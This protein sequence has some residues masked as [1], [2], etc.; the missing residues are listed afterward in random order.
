MNP[1]AAE[2]ND[3]RPNHK[4]F[5]TN[6]IA[7]NFFSFMA[8][9][10]AFTQGNMMQYI[11]NK[12]TKIEIGPFPFIVISLF[13]KILKTMSKTYDKNIIIKIFILLHTNSQLFSE[14]T[15]IKLPK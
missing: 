7:K 8:K 6:N 1:Q 13:S 4:T 14:Y 11:M 3:S 2:I 5:I 9:N 15:I 10:L 12:L